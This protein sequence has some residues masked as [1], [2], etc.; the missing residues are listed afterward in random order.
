MKQGRASGGIDNYRP[1]QGPTNIDEPR[2]PGLHGDNCGS[3]GYQNKP[4]ERKQSSGSP[5]L[6][7]QVHHCGSQD[8]PY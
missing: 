1:P 4:A 3:Q 5:G 8:A 2:A 6:G 7:G